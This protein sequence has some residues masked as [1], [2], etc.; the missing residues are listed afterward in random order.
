MQSTPL[1]SLFLI[2]PLFLADTADGATESDAYI[3]RHRLP[4][5]GRAADAYTSDESHCSGLSKACD[6]PLSP[7]EFAQHARHAHGKLLPETLHVKANFVRAHDV[8]SH[9]DVDVQLC[10]GAG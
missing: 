6:L 9:D 5:S 3:E 4:Y 10:R 7:L 2:D 8:D 1:R